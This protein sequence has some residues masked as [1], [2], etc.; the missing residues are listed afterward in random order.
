M[1][2]RTG[3]ENETRRSA[4]AAVVATIYLPLPSLPTTTS[5]APPAPRHS[6]LAGRGLFA[7]L[8]RGGPSSTSH[9]HQLAV[10][11]PARRA[12]EVRVVEIINF[13]AFATL[14]FL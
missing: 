6:H 14:L 11:F 2:K 12:P 1:T 8:Q 9:G 3:G 13:Y 5:G 7:V 4:L 10:S